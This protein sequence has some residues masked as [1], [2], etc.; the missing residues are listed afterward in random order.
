[1]KN[2]DIKIFYENLISSYREENVYLE[3]IIESYTLF[4]KYLNFKDNYFFLTKAIEV[5][6]SADIY[7]KDHEIQE[8]IK[9]LK[10]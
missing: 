8:L 1:M 2:E 5:L 6:N 3:K 4:I 7:K 10:G 9:K